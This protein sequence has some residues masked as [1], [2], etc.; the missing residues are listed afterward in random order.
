MHEQ[1]PVGIA[2][3]LGTVA[4]AAAAVAAIVT[5]VLEGDHT[6]ETL[7]ALAA[8]VLAFWKVMDGRYK[9][10]TAR[11]AT[12]T[13][14]WTSSGSTTSASGATASALQAYRDERAD[15]ADHLLPADD[16]PPEIEAHPED[17]PR[18]IAPDE[19]DWMAQEEER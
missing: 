1:I 6:P 5:A 3:K 19:G 15:D 4:G 9:Q 18:T 10:A 11:R 8:A 17:D 12:S 16:A 13:P 7:G 2:T 14:I